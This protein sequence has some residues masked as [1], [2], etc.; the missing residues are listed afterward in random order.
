MGRSYFVEVP[1]TIVSLLRTH[2]TVPHHTLPDALADPVALFLALRHKDCPIDLVALGPRL[3]DPLR[4][5]QQIH[6]VDKQIPVVLLCEPEQYLALKHALQFTPLLGREVRCFALQDDATTVAAIQ[7]ILQ[8][9]TQRRRYQAQI[10]T[11]NQQIVDLAASRPSATAYLGQLLDYA[12]IGIATLDQQGTVVGWN[13]TASMLFQRAEREV[14]GVSFASLFP[15]AAH[16]VVEQIHRQGTPT[17]RAR[18]PMLVQMTTAQGHTRWL[19]FTVAPLPLARHGRGTLLLFEDVTARV[20][21]E[22]EREASQHRLSFLAELSLIL[23]ASLDYHATLAHLAEALVPALADWCIIDWI[24]ADD[25]LACVA[26]ATTDAALVA[27]LHTLRERY[28]RTWYSDQLAAEVLRQR[29]GVLIPTF[30]AESLAALVWDQEHLRLMEGLNPQSAMAVPILVR[31]RVL[32]VM[33]LA[34]TGETPT[35]T[36]EDL[37]FAEDVANRAALVIDNARLYA[38]AQ[39]AIQLRDDFLS[40]AAH[41]LKTPVTTVLGSAQLLQRHLASSPTTTDRDRRR[42]QIL[43]D[44]VWRLQRLIHT[45]LDPARIAAGQLIIEPTPVD[46]SHIVRQILDALQ[47]TLDR[48]RVVSHG[49]DTPCIIDGDPLRLEQVVQNILQNA[50]KYSPQGG[51]IGID[52]VQLTHDVQLTVTDEGI[53]IPADEIAK[54]TERFYRAGNVHT[55]TVGGMGIGLYLVKEIIGAHRGMLHIESQQGVG[56]Q[57]QIDLP[58]GTGSQSP[59]QPREDP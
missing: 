16:A 30:S 27:P 4:V 9:T 25:R 15:P 49:L 18:L 31:D 44:Q 51:I 5:A 11:A 46:L 52:L 20:H 28:P 13:R 48:H 43:I 3:A 12:P 21:A 22:E 34:R 35:Y 50:I 54:V 55:H 32:A 1:S 58:R 45:L 6:Q 36:G 53:G 2:A 37:R 26:V 47:P 14:L 39:R 57:I 29:K 38:D 23:G 19:Q 41:E 24:E 10:H 59:E 17:N 8:R 56:T 42:M 33:T 40:L 7:D